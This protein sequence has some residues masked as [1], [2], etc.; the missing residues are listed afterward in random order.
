MNSSSLTAYVYCQMID[1]RPFVVCSH[2]VYMKIQELMIKKLS[3]PTWEEVEQACPLTSSYKALGKCQLYLYINPCSPL[4]FLTELLNVAETSA[5][6]ETCRY[7]RGYSK[8]FHNTSRMSEIQKKNV[9]RKGVR[10]ARGFR[11]SQ[12]FLA[13]IRT[14][15]TTTLERISRGSG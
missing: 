15:S 3:L 6:K 11:V 1:P 2:K 7:E 8:L 14:F 9:K 5:L 10:S 13:Q 12:R 4:S